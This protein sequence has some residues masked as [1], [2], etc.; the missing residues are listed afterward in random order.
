[1]TVPGIDAPVALSIVAAVGD[2]TRFRTPEKL[3]A[4]LALNPRVRPAGLRGAR[5]GRARFGGP[6]GSRRQTKNARCAARP[7]NEGRGGMF[8]YKPP[9]PGE[10]IFPG[11][12]PPPWHASRGR[13]GR[14]Q[15]HRA[16]LAP[17]H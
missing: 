12:F 8:P 10:R 5:G 1:M 6:G 2:F 14:P 15:A 11:G 13:R 16:V 7:R 9:G 4:Y 3:V 17:D